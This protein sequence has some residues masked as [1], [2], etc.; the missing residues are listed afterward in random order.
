MVLIKSAHEMWENDFLEQL[1][2]KR[3]ATGA[4]GQQPKAGA[5]S[6][7]ATQVENERTLLG[8]GSYLGVFGEGG[9][10]EVRHFVSRARERRSHY[11]FVKGDPSRLVT[12]SSL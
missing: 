3:A 8:I 4:T 10:K 9:G 7:S 2:A 1:R 12:V 11:C 5:A 6:G